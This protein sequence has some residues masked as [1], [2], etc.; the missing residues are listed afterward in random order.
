MDFQGGMEEHTVLD[1][2]PE[3]A[4]RR[5]ERSTSDDGRAVA[6]VFELPST[7]D[8]NVEREQMRRRR[9][10][11]GA[12]DRVAREGRVRAVDEHLSPPQAVAGLRA[13]GETRDGLKIAF[14]SS[15]RA[16]KEASDVA[17]AA[18]KLNSYI[19]Q[20]TRFGDGNLDR[21]TS[22]GNK[23]NKGE[24]VCEVQKTLFRKERHACIERRSIEFGTWSSIESKVWLTLTLSSIGFNSR[25]I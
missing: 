18:R 20:E 16:A 17:W 10:S 11:K 5:R 15:P 22:R 4:I 24:A 13:K 3:D 2:Q 9:D 14:N 19:L 7:V 25:L 1:R 21:Y 12:H 8:L 6:K 23:G